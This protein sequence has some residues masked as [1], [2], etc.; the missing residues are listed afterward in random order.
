LGGDAAH[1]HSPLGARGMNLGIED[2]WVYADC[3]FD[4]L[5]GRIERIGEY[6]QLRA[7]L[8]RQLVR[9]IAAMTRVMRGRPAPLRWLRD[10]LVPPLMGLA[11]AQRLLVRTVSG[12]DHPLRTA[13]VDR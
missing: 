5:H 1:I 2:A 3:A 6:A 11:P 4:A 10:G 9:R 13:L 7:P 8:H 12:Q